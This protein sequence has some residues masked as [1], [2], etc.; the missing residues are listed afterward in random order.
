MVIG[1]YLIANPGSPI[2][3]KNHRTCKRNFVLKIRMYIKPIAATIIN[4]F[5]E[6]AK[7][8]KQKKQIQTKRNGYNKFH[9]Y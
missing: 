5:T 7:T 6:I 8:I 9:I 1:Q 3:K 4:I 2:M